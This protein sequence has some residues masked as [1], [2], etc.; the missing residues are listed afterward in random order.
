[1]EGGWVPGGCIQLSSSI[2]LSVA[3]SPDE[4]LAIGWCPS[5]MTL[6]MLAAFLANE[7][8]NVVFRIR[9]RAAMIAS[10]QGLSP[11]IRSDMLKKGTVGTGGVAC[12]GIGSGIVTFCFCLSIGH[13]SLLLRLVLIVRVWFSIRINLSSR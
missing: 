4:A 2:T 13:V 3:S 1:M 10:C 6:S 8:S 9:M 5:T 12:G 7:W 11:S